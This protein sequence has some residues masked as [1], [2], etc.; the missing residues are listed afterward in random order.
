MMGYTR[1]QSLLVHVR[2]GIDI[3]SSC[4]AHQGG[5]AQKVHEAA[6]AMIA[7]LEPRIA[8]SAPH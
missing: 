8:T 2:R 3:E 4:T 1:P 5:F 7:E 6:S